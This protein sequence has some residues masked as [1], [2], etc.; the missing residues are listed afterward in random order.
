MHPRLKKLGIPLLALMLLTGCDD[1][2]KEEAVVDTPPEVSNHEDLKQDTSIENIP[3]ETKHERPTTKTNVDLVWVSAESRKQQAPLFKQ[4][5][6]DADAIV[7]NHLTQEQAKDNNTI[8]GGTLHHVQ[9][10]PTFT[11]NQFGR[12]VDVTMTCTINGYNQE[13][14]FRHVPF[15]V[16]TFTKQYT[17]IMPT[18]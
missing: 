7:E 16:T 1:T 9:D 4:C 8:T 12:T 2:T 5:Q 18:H 14:A 11:F 17:L 6:D 10:N 13:N 3:V 15:E